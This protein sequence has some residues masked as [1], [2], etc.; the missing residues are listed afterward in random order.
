MLSTKNS[1]QIQFYQQVESKGWKN[2]YCANINQRKT[3]M[4]ILILG[5][6]DFRTKKIIRES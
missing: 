1:F 2:I 3:R 4:D 5:K 6:E